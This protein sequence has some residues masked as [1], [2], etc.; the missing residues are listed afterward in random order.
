MGKSS[1]D[2]QYIKIYLF[3]QLAIFI[4]KHKRSLN[5]YLFNFN[6][7][8]VQTFKSTINTR[9]RLSYFFSNLIIFRIQKDFLFISI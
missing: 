7:L 2:T 4:K 9:S 5:L 1:R 3:F 6:L 8:S